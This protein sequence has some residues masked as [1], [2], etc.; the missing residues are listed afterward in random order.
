MMV[1]KSL[2]KIWQESIRVGNV[3]V[4]WPDTRAVILGPHWFGLMVTV[5]L[6]IGGTLLNWSVIDTK[7][8]FLHL[9]ESTGWMLKYLVCPTFF[10]ASLYFL[11][12]TACTDPGIVLLR[13]WR[14]HKDQRDHEGG[15][16]L[17]AD[18]DEDIVEDEEKNADGSKLSSYEAGSRRFR[19][20]MRKTKIYCRKCDYHINA[21]GTV[22]HCS[23]C[24]NCI[25][26]MDHHCPWMGQCIGKNNF[27]AFI[28]FNV[29][30]VTY[31]VQL[32][33]LAILL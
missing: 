26:G 28:R 1:P 11:F 27:D 18:S 12:Q 2:L 25:L 33:V 16:L 24:D 4:F 23:I 7:V 8:A 14:R 15:T 6:L 13:T 20:R 30:W 31:A 5:L 32:L 10:S 22:E 9:S 3:R 29:C 19:N 21:L 17:H